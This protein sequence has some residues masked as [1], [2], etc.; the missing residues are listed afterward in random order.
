MYENE[1]FI[2]QLPCVATLN[3]ETVQLA[4]I[5]DAIGLDIF[6]TKHSSKQPAECDVIHKRR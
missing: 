2:V 3:P 5:I 4:L 6:L 1:S